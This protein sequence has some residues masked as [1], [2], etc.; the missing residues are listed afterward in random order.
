VDISALTSNPSVRAALLNAQSGGASAQPTAAQLERDRK[1][2]LSSDPKLVGGAG[3]RP[4]TPADVKKAASQ[5]EAIIIRQLLEPSITPIMSGGLGGAEGSGG[6]VYG[7]ML[8]DVLSNS[9]AQGGGLGWAKLL[10]KQLSSHP[11]G[12]DNINKA[13]SES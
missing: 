3:P 5:F 7:Y 11:A 10:E 13:L 8:T 6:G 2:L 1:T 4:V 9:F 12:A